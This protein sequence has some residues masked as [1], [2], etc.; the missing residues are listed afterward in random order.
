MKLLVAPIETITRQGQRQRKRGKIFLEVAWPAL[1]PVL[2]GDVDWPRPG[3]RQRLPYRRGSRIMHP[4]A[5]ILQQV[6]Q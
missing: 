4:I 1:G 6:S 2:G 3:R 5:G